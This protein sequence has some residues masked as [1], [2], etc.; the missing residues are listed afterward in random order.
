[1][2]RLRLF[3]EHKL[4][5]MVCIV[6]RACALGLITLL[7]AFSA[8]AATYTNASTTFSWIDPATHSKVGHLTAPSKFNTC[9]TTPP[10]LDDTISDVIPIGFNFLYGATSYN[11]LRIESNGR[12][13]FNNANCSAGT[14]SIGPPQTYTQ[15]YPVAAMNNT[16]KAFG[17]DLDPT[18]LVNVPNYPTAGSKTS[19][20]SN[21][22]CYISYASLGTSPNRKFV[23]S[24]VNVPEWV[25]ASNTSGSFTFQI[26]LN[27]DGTFIFQYL[28]IVHGGTGSAQ[29]GWQL[30]HD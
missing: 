26:I 14:N 18:N 8:A 5:N 11:S 22:V 23:V 7:C 6:C 4:R 21:A 13:Q 1:M 25:T 24:W 12:V 17:V 28:N 2:T 29:I 30:T 9:G 19:C 27:E 15:L 10:T 16:M 3:S 20:T